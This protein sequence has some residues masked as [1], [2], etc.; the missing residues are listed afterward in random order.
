MYAFV[1][2]DI[3]KT[4]L[5]LLNIINILIILIETKS[6]H[7]FKYEKKKYFLIVLLNVTYKLI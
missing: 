4:K 1:Q 6:Y 3:S 2:I 5:L 7:L